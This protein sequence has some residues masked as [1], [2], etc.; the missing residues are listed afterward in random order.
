MPLIFTNDALSTINGAISDTA[1]T[2]VLTTDAN[3]FPA[4]TGD[5]YAHLTL[6]DFDGNK[7]IVKLTARTGT[8]CTVVRGQEGTTAAAWPDG[9]RIELRV[10]AQAFTENA[11]QIAENAQSLFV[12]ASAA[13]PAL[14][15]TGAGTISLKAGTVVEVDG[16]V[17]GF[18]TDTA[19]TMPTLTAGT[20]YAVWIAPDGSLEATADFVSPPVADARQIG[21]FHYAAGGNATGT[22]GGDT[23]PAINE[24]SLWDLKWRPACP[25]PRG[26]ALVAGGFWCDI[27]LLGVEHLVNGTSKYNVTI[28]DG[29]SPPK[30]PTLFGGNGTTAYSSLTWW[31]AAEVMASHGKRLLSYADF[32]AAAYGTTENSSGGTDPVSTILRQ[33]YTSKWGIMLATGNLYVWGDEFGGPDAGAAWANT[34]GGRGQ[35]F[36]QSNALLLGGNWDSAA[37]SGSR[38]SNWS[39]APSSSGSSLGARGRCEHLTLV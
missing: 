12:K 32:A 3:L 20:D 34:N 37:N 7:E 28:A 6:F 22:S 5:E 1:T 30:I 35:V 16:A 21:G 11:A 33:A 14:T 18:A 2:I 23:T 39:V 25:D 19:V 10:T 31:E 36:Q 27:Y 8:S 15:K 29:S 17:H 9:S 4:P 24:F 26:M 13:A 38:A